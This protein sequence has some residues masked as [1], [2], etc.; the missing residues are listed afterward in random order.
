MDGEVKMNKCM[1]NDFTSC[2]VAESV[3][4]LLQYFGGGG[5][6]G[7]NNNIIIIIIIII[8]MHLECLRLSQ[9]EENGLL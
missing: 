2:P 7:G 3:T 4:V 1:V 9:F 5:D 6:D 8:R